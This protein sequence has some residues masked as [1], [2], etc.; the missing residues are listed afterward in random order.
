[1]CTGIA[2]AEKRMIEI[3][4]IIPFVPNS[5]VDDARAEK[6]KDIFITAT[7]RYNHSAGNS[8]KDLTIFKKTVTKGLVTSD[9]TTG[10]A[11]LG[12][13]TEYSFEITLDKFKNY[14]FMDF[15]NKDQLNNL[16]QNLCKFIG[17]NQGVHWE[18][19]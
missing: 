19:P 13:I 18:A 4:S 7:Y 10:I 11:T 8:K 3:C 6:N 17:I 16:Q 14:V 15:A 12:G 9:V 2:D 1:M 5:T